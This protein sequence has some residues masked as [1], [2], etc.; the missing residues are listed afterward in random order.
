MVNF[1]EVF[2]ALRYEPDLEWE[3]IEVVLLKHI[4]TV[5]VL[6]QRMMRA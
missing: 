4:S 5:L 2:R 6:E 1:T 3:F